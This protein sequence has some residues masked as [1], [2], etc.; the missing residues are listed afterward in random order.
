M[1][2]PLAR[3]VPLV[4]LPAILSACTAREPAPSDVTR[5]VKLERPARA[6]DFTERLFSGKV[7][8]ASGMNL[9][10]RVGGPLECLPV[11]EGDFVREGQLIARV[12]PRDYELQLSVAQARYEQ[13]RSE[14]DRLTELKQRGSVSDNDYEKAAGGERML[15]A[16]LQHARNQLE[17]TRLTAPFPGY[18]QSV[19]Y[20]EGE[21]ADAGMPV[22]TLLDVSAYTVEADLPLALFVRRD[23]FDS[24]WCR[25]PLLPDSLYPLQLTGY[26]VKADNSQLF[27]A[28]F[29]LDPGA[30]SRIAPGM[31][32]G[33]TVRLANGQ[34]G[35][36]TLPLS[37]VF[38][39]QGQTCVW[40]Y[41][42]ATSTVRRREVVTGN[43]EAGG[44][45]RITG[46]LSPEDEVVV[47]GVRALQA[48]QAVE[49][50]QEAAET[51]V[52][53]LL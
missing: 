50:L 53:G 23:D 13:H 24:F 42:P 45:I 12:D 38:N 34:L 18:I 10:F 16:Q 3:L 35:A 47:S 19:R 43:L 52:G 37:A 28:R 25:P 6:P 9:T 29:R 4:L 39:E 2:K 33:I 20:R 48:G 51:N 14:F 21:M 32:V 22:A 31:P 5:K 8:E 26:Q 17:D 49:P 7:A 1:K 15:A 27:R 44:R 30:D 40:I 41:D 36:L 46:G 11:R